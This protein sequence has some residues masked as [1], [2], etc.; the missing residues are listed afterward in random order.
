MILADRRKF[1]HRLH[2]FRG[3]CFEKKGWVIDMK[4]WCIGNLF[5]WEISISKKIERKQINVSLVQWFDCYSA[6]SSRRTRT[7][8]N[9]NMEPRLGNISH[10]WRILGS[11]WFAIFLWIQN[12]VLTTGIPSHTICESHK[13]GSNPRSKGPGCP[14]PLGPGGRGEGH[15]G[16]VTLMP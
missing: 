15:A 16:P 1:S 5:G 14:C 4:H 3:S 12:G 9:S 2:N 7:P 10:C 8:E 13:P 11:R 6:R